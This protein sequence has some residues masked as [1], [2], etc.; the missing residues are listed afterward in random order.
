MADSSPSLP[1][2]QLPERKDRLWDPDGD[3][4][5]YSKLLK[6]VPWQRLSIAKLFT[7][8]GPH[9]L[10]AL[11][12]LVPLQTAGVCLHCLPACLSV[13]LCLFVCVCA[14]ARAQRAGGRAGVGG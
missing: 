6:S 14:R 10:P 5:L 12:R 11:S 13:C 1:P 2:P 7:S 4:L 9:G 3:Q 8:I